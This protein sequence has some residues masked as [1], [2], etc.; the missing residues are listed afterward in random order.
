MF[1]R[2]FITLIVYPRV[3]IQKNQFNQFNQKKFDFSS[4][5]LDIINI[6]ILQGISFLNII[7][8]CVYLA[9][10]VDQNTL[11]YINSRCSSGETYLDLNCK[12]ILS[13]YKND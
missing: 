2:F 13:S 11:S 12:Y 7:N 9:V 10:P 8:I 3:F 1:L 4:F 5:S 6:R